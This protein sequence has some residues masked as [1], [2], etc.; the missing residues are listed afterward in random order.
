[1]KRSS[2]HQQI[3]PLELKIT[4]PIAYSYFSGGDPNKRKPAAGSRLAL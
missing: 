2:K 3:T 4:D 1:M